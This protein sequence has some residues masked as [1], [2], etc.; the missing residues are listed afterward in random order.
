VQAGTS[1]T[2]EWRLIGNSTR[3]EVA[4][5]SQSAGAP[6][7]IAID[8]VGVKQ[9]WERLSS[10]PSAAL[11]DVRTKAEWNYVGLPDLTT[12]GRK[13]ILVE[14]Q[15]FPEGRID[16]SFT[17]RLEAS[18]NAAG[19][20]KNAEIFFICRSGGRSRSAALA[21][22]AAGYS[23]CRNVAEGFE[24]PLD[25]LRHRGRIGGWKSAGLPWAQG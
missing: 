23:R 14:W 8:D 20:G 1:G 9:V 10:D 24:G 6:P 13:P 17:V 12:I 15:N 21:M 16:P 3:W 19:V 5:G 7:I 4:L 25:P 2:G 22:T 18:L 11:V